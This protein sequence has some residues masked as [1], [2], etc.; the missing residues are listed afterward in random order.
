M[1]GI[2]HTIFLLLLHMFVINTLQSSTQIILS[3]VMLDFIVSLPNVFL[4]CV[5]WS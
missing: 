3:V 4:E 5:L 1:M 2:P